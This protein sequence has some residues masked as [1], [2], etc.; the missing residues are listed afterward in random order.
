MRNDSMPLVVEG[1]IHMLAGQGPTLPSC[2]VQSGLS[3][4]PVVSPHRWLTCAGLWRSIPRPIV[5]AF[6]GKPT[7]ASWPQQYRET[8]DFSQ[9]TSFSLTNRNFSLSEIQHRYVVTDLSFA[10][11]STLQSCPP[12]T[13]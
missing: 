5:G 8:T 7:N 10:S 4:A 1:Q 13:S 9:T 12:P 2:N 3:M 11:V 6:R